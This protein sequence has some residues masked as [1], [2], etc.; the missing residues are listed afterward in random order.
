MKDPL[1]MLKDSLRSIILLKSVLVMILTYHKV[2]IMYG[3]LRWGVACW[4]FSDGMLFTK[5][6]P[7]TGDDYLLISYELLR[8]NVNSTI[9][10]GFT[11][12]IGEIYSATLNGADLV[13]RNHGGVRL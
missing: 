3:P 12:S 6:L 5:E 7:S 10:G 9:E 2:L 11:N 4:G 13:S 1:G 8:I